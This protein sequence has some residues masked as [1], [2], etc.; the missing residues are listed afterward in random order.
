MPYRDIERV[1]LHI[2]GTVDGSFCLVAG[3]VEQRAIPKVIRPLDLHRCLTECTGTV[4]Q[5]L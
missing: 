1:Y 5:E 4:V 2:G 3:D